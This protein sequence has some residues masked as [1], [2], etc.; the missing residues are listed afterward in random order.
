MIKKMM[1]GNEAC[2]YGAIIAGCRFFAGYPITPSSEIAEELAV[3]LP[4]VEG[5][6]IQMEDEIASMA[7]VLGASLN[8]I[9]SLTA[10]SGPGFSLKQENIGYACQTEIPCVIVNVQRGGPS[11]GSPTM[12]S[13]E[14]F[15]QSRWGTHGDHFIVVLSPTSVQETFDLTVKS[16]NISEKY[17]TPVILLMDEIVGHMTE[18]MILPEPGEIEIIDRKKPSGKP[19]DFR[20][21]ENTEDGV[22][23]MAAFGTG[24][25][26]H[27]TGLMHDETG[28]PTNNSEVIQK[29]K[30]RWKL[31]FDLARDSVVFYELADNEDMEYLVFS[32][33]SSA[34]CARK[35]VKIAREHGLKVGSMKALTLWPFPDKELEKISK[36]LKGIVVA[37]MNMG[38]AIREVERAVGKDI[39]VLGANR[40]DGESMHPD[41]ILRVIQK[42]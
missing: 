10:T 1:H 27:V 40:Y 3:L 14:D 7:A 19:E 26:H 28:F 18:K 13:Q 9:K 17:R 4:Q 24:Y 2:A 32:Y 42:F 6:F 39:K 11:T 12:P 35:A 30:D 15:M 25:R 23:P 41:D 34:R 22:P 37:E 29:Q 21:Y 8:G 36:G 38:Q 5:K 20:P 31:K 16:F 33:G